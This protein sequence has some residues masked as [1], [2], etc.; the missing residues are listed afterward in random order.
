MVRA[1]RCWKKSSRVSGS[2]LF[3]VELEE[4]AD[5][6]NEVVVHL[7][8]APGEVDVERR[9]LTR[10]LE[11]LSLE[12]D[13]VIDVPHQD[14]FIPF[15]VSLRECLDPLLAC[16]LRQH[17]ERPNNVLERQRDPDVAVVLPINAFPRL[18]GWAIGGGTACSVETIS[19]A[20][21]HVAFEVAL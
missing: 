18:C 6:V 13:E 19:Q 8:T 21:N 5:D 2:R 20:D 7:L 4:V 10:A 11:V 1:R 15:A 3:L 9:V 16:P 12:L 14:F 17:V